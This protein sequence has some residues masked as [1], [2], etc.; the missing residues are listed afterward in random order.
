MSIGIYDIR[1]AKDIRE[2]LGL[3]CHVLKVGYEQLM[4][5]NKD[6]AKRKLLEKSLKEAHD[7][8]MRDTLEYTYR[9]LTNLAFLS[10]S[11]DRFDGQRL[12]D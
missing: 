6:Y 7:K 10:S 11:F 5:K 9:F 3:A 1:T 4:D 12:Q 2:A 8:G